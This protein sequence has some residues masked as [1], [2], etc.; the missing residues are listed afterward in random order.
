MNYLTSKKIPA[1]ILYN[2][3]SNIFIAI[4]FFFTLPIY[5]NYMDAINFKLYC[6]FYS[7]VFFFK[8]LEIGASP[9]IVRYISKKILL[10][11]W[12]DAVRNFIYFYELVFLFLT[13]I[14]FF[15]LFFFRDLISMNLLNVEFVDAVGMGPSA[16]NSKSAIKFVLYIFSFIMLFKLLAV[17]YRGVLYGFEMQKYFN[18]TRV[19]FEFLTLFVGIQI[20]IIF[21][22]NSFLYLYFWILFT[23]VLETA[24]YKFII[25]KKINVKINLSLKKGFMIFIANSNFM[26][27]IA[28]SS[29]LW[30][31]TSNIDKLL[32][33]NYLNSIS[34]GIYI[35][36][37]SFSILPLLLIVPIF[38]SAFP[39][40]N[41]LFHKKRLKEYHNIFFSLIFLSLVVIFTFII[42]YELF[43]DFFMVLI[44]DKNELIVAKT[45]F[46]NFF[47]GYLLLSFSFI[48][49]T[50]LK[51][52]GKMKI[53]T[54]GNIFWFLLIVF[55]L[56]KEILFSQNPI[57]YSFNGLIINCIFFI[58][59]VLAVTLK[60]IAFSTIISFLKEFLLVFSTF[61]IMYYFSK[62]ITFF[63]SQ[64]L[65]VFNCFYLF[66]SSLFV[67][68]ILIL[69]SSSLKN[70]IK[71][72]DF[73]KKII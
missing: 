34:Y 59:F 53:H 68:I 14:L 44:I 47:I 18:I 22:F 63:N 5:S 38:E 58:S 41:N 73:F 35:M 46:F 21:N 43:A 12:L 57:N 49:Y 23:A 42:I 52:L 69:S 55:S 32:F 54:I 24:I 28:L 2:L 27:N 1:N 66:L 16:F 7:S 40:L 33:A 65:I 60:Y 70:S 8:F 26:L 51:I 11:N 9:T 30:M 61:A 17:L 72:N 37:T 31:V 48:F 56:I 6:F 62:K 45:L 15:L 19:I 3:I 29:F 50:K 36:V 4:I 20:I 10:E 25:I 13:S 67:G 39:H 64:D 71:N